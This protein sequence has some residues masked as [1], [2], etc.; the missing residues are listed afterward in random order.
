MLDYHIYQ[1]QSQRRAKGALASFS[2]IDRINFSHRHNAVKR[3]ELIINKKYILSFVSIQL[4]FKYHTDNSVIN[5]KIISNYQINSYEFNDYQLTN[6][7]N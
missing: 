6:Y 3:L 4:R 2:H 1:R 7:I 5:I